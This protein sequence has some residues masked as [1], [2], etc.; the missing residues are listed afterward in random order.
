MK[1][2]LL[3]QSLQFLNKEI[4]DG[5]HYAA[6]R[7]N[8]QTAD[9]LERE[10]SS[11]SNYSGGGGYV[12]IDDDFLSFA[13]EGATGSFADPI[14][15]GKLYTLI[16]TNANNSTRIARLC[17]GLLQNAAGLIQDGTFDDNSGAGGLSG[18]GSPLAIAY[19]NQFIYLFPSLVVGFKVSTSNI[20]QFEMNMTIQ[21]ESPFKVHESRII[22][23]ASYASEANPNTTLISVLTSFYMNNQTAIL[24]PVLG[25]TTVSI[26]LYFGASLNIAHALEQK[27]SRAQNNLVRMGAASGSAVSFRGRR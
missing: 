11:L 22:N 26:G 15:E 12:G 14:N 24:Y 4:S 27:T 10:A 1:K 5:A 2:I 17:P 8:Y 18:T 13:G 16:L 23:I 9:D 25:S 20:N 21:K 7:L 3:G 6:G 19:F